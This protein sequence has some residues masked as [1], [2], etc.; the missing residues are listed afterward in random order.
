MIERLQIEGF[1]AHVKTRIKLDPGVTTIVGP[2]DVGKSSVLRAL[3][4]LCA[5]RPSGT[6]HHR[7]GAPFC[8][9]MAQVDG[10][11]VA[12]VRAGDDN[13]Y[14]LDGQQYRAFGAQVPEPIARLLNVGPDNYQGQHDAPY[15]FGLSAGEVSQELNT[16]VNLGAID[17]TLAR[18]ASQCR[19]A[20]QTETI[21]E[22]Q[23]REAEAK[24]AGMLWVNAMAAEF[25]ALEALEAKAAAAKTAQAEAHL[26][27]TR[28]HEIKE[29]AEG[30]SGLV[31]ALQ[32]VIDK[33]NA[34][35]RA[36][37]A[38]QAARTALAAA[39]G[40]QTQANQR[41]PDLAP[42]SGLY[43]G[44]T[45][46]TTAAQQARQR[47]GEAKEANSRVQ[48]AAAALAQAKTTL[49]D[50]TG[51]QCPVCGNQMS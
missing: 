47:L 38:A 17:S 29:V 34:A 51:G 36:G 43:Q 32:A 27:L 42:L 10:H 41:T 25:A 37:K 2:S 20:A 23:L 8:R 31:A 6:A 30:L 9:V 48:R 4:W 18:L 15:W 28:V 3:W 24:A 1:Q 21:V 13:Y 14:E 35:G 45:A 7:H 33:G 11:R 46:A 19:A 49:Q 12:R 50:E 16:I 22:G 44:A 5:N 40:A 39:Q 26:R